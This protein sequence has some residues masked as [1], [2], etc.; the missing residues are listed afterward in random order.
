VRSHTLAE[1][2]LSKIS[3]SIMYLMSNLK[4]FE[5]EGRPGPVHVHTTG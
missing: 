5:I 4:I 1:P 2:Q 3:A